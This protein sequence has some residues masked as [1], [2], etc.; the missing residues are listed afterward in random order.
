MSVHR[1]RRCLLCGNAAIDAKTSGRVVTTTCLACRAVLVIEFDP[2]DEPTIRAR[3]ERVDVTA[4][5]A[6]EPDPD[7]R[8]ARKR[9]TRN[10]P[11][12]LAVSRRR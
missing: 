7:T 6:C 4:A 1:V 3:I 5:E 12:A 11:I 2:P 10:S 8:T 9:D